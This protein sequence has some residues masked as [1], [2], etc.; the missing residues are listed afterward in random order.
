MASAEDRKLHR[1][2]P[3][4]VRVRNGTPAIVAGLKQA[5]GCFRKEG[6]DFVFRSALGDGHSISEHMVWLHGMLQHDYKDFRRSLPNG[7]EIVVRIYSE[8]RDVSI[9]TQALLLAHKLQLPIEISVWP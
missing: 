6:R 3:V 7:A 2:A 5:A 4:E 9:S 8:S 1:V